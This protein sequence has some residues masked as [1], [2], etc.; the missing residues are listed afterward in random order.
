MANKINTFVTTPIVYHGVG[1]L[2]RLPAAI[3]NLG[4]RRPAV[5][6]DPGVAAAGVLDQLLSVLKEKPACF[7]EVEPEPPETLVAEGVQF[8]KSHNCDLVIALGGGSAIDTAKMAAVLLGNPGTVHDY[9][10]LDKVR[11]PG[12]PMIAVPTTAGT[13]SEVTPAAVFTDTSTN[14]KK[15][16]RSLP[17]QPRV[18]ILDP[19]LTVSLPQN[20][21]ASTGID[22]LTHAIEAYTSKNATLMS[23][24]AAEK[25]IELIA[26]HVL[27]AYGDGRDLSAREGMLMGSYLAGISFGIANVAAVHSIAQ[28]I[29]G[30][31]KIPHGTANA[32]MLPYVMDFNREA[33]MGKYA[34]VA[35]LMGEIVTG[36]TADDASGK[37]VE[38]VRKLTV[39]L[40]IPQHIK[41]LGIGEDEIDGI[42]KACL[43]S[44]GRLLVLNPREAGIDDVRRI[45]KD[46]Y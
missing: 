4:A 17:L 20:P 10:G 7:T 24:L 42:A 19:L 31:Y 18:A 25:A 46:A 12:V 2:G 5:F 44:Q 6:T 43:E 23:D 38:A 29:G 26:S 30:M 36:L 9:W 35:E 45:L 8:L 21:T 40:Q 28:T 41:E 16:V 27:R 37:A 3:E 22:A 1:A 11:K 34:L 14:I 33:C 13:G 32:V 15:G 39:E